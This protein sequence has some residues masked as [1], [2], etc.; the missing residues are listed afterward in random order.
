MAHLSG[1]EILGTVRKQFLAG[2]LVALP[3][4]ATILI[5]LWIFQYVDNILRPIFA[6]FLG[7]YV[8]GMGFVAVVVLIYLIGLL[9]SNVAGKEVIRYAQS[10]VSRVPV[11]RSI[12]TTIRQIFESFSSS[13][14]TAFRETVLVEF[15]RKGM[16]ALAFVTNY[17]PSEK[18]LISIYVPTTPNPTSGFLEFIPE[19]EVIHTTIPVDQAMKTII[20]GGTLTQ[21]EIGVRLHN[22]SVDS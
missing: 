18:N 11:V 12:Y 14:S 5:L 1:K 17:M 22:I 8:P 16:Y 9:A 10:L 2:I 13:R 20:S 4:G 21:P 3:I 15:P 6:Y 7:H 19:D